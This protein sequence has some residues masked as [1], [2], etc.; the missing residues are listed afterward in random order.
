[1]SHFNILSAYMYENVINYCTE[2]KYKLL[3]HSKPP[4]FNLQLFTNLVTISISFSL[5]FFLGHKCPHSSYC[6]PIGL[7]HIMQE[8]V[9]VNNAYN[10]AVPNLRCS[11]YNGGNLPK[12]RSRHCPH[13][14]LPR[15][16]KLIYQGAYYDFGI[17]P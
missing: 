14:I 7:F 12:V 1:M 3:V 15:P 16:Y 17:S 6:V 9:T 2:F 13:G 10:C 8:T 4:V 11:P 5:F